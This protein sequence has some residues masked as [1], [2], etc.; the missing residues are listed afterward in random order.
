[1]YRRKFTT[2]FNGKLL[3][4]TFTTIR[5]HDSNLNRL[6]ERH[7]ICLRDTDIGIASILSVK[8]ITVDRISEHMA[9]IDTGHN[10]AYLLGLLRKFYPDITAATQF[11]FILYQWKELDENAYCQLAKKHL[12]SLS[13]AP[14][15]NLFTKSKAA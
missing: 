15:E 13:L 5:L 4:N 9:H 11:D 2:N 10:K 7:T 1:M 14:S 8:I 3:C 12:E 6:G